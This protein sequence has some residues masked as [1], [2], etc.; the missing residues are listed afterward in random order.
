MNGN[1]GIVLPP[2]AQTPAPITNLSLL[3]KGAIPEALTST[4][5]ALARHYSELLD[6]LARLQK[7]HAMATSS[8]QAVAQISL[9]QQP[10]DRDTVCGAE[11]VEILDAAINRL[12][13]IVKSL[14]AA[15]TSPIFT[16]ALEREESK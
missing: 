4:A 3:H 16:G 15:A 11:E 10:I 6:T 5:A 7:A 1:G 14:G 12:S 9:M 13:A 2:G 8:Q